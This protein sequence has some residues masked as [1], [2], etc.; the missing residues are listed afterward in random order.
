MR[1]PG[2]IGQNRDGLPATDGGFGVG[3]KAAQFSA[4]TEDLER[5]CLDERADDPVRPCASGEV[6][7][8]AALHAD[9]GE[10][11]ALRPPIDH[12]R[13]RQQRAGAGGLGTPQHHETSGVGVRQRPEQ[14]GPDDAEHR[15]VRPDAESER[16]HHG[17]G[18]AGA[19]S[20]LTSGVPNVLQ[21]RVHYSARSAT[22]GSVRVA[23]RAGRYVASAATAISTSGMVTNVIGSVA[24]TPKSMLFITRVS[25][26][27]AERP[28]TTPTRARF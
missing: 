22:M 16:E 28:T 8:L 10:G 23:R 3:E 14:Y 25:R 9:V 5:S 26:N 17:Q 12:I 19:G 18:E 2:G 21:D 11:S 13:N 7:A 6:D 1:A 4:G 27:A 24:P 20:K 15:S